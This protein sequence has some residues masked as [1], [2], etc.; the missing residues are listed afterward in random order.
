MIKVLKFSTQYCGPCKQYSTVFKEVK[1]GNPSIEFE[2]IDAENSDE[3]VQKYRIS[4]VPTTVILVDD[5]VAFKKVGYM[6]KEVLQSEIDK[7]VK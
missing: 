2:E 7:L 6:N 4:G 5:E 1:E 3:L